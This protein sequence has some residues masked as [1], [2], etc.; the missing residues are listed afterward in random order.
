MWIVFVPVIVHRTETGAGTPG[1]CKINTNHDNSLLGDTDTG[2]YLLYVSVSFS[3]ISVAFLVEFSMADMR[4]ACSLQ[5]FS[6]TAL[7]KTCRHQATPFLRVE[8]RRVDL[9]NP[10]REVET[11]MKAIKPQPASFAGLRCEVQP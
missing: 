5:L 7:Y 2:L 11:P 6:I 1:S 9:T 8:P 4:A 10:P 3:R